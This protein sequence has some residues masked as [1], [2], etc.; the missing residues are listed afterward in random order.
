MSTPS[1]PYWSTRAL[2]RAN[3]N[4]TCVSFLYW[5]AEAA[6]PLEVV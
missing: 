1:R 2:G 3:E 6:P 5:I 4:I